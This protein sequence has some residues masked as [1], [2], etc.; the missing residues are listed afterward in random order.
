MVACFHQFMFFSKHTKGK[1][2]VALHSGL[3]SMYFMQQY[4]IFW[5]H[6]AG[7]AVG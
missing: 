4:F 3:Y 2:A 6:A 7:G 1:E 5:G